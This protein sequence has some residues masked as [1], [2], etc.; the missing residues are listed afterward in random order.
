VSARLT[1]TE[2]SKR[3]VTRHGPVQALIPVNLDVPPGQF[4]SIVGPSGCGKSTLVRLISGLIPPTGGTVTLDG[5]VVDRPVT[6][7]GIVFQD[8]VLLDW[9]TTLGNV[10]L[11]GKV[12]GMPKELRERRGR[13]LLEMA[14]LS[15]FEDRRP[16]EL[17]GGMRQRVALCR[18][19]LHEPPLLLM[20]E[21]FGSL[22]ALTREQMASELQA[23][24]MR[25][26]PTMVFVTHSIPEAVT[27]SDRVI[28]MSSRPGR[29]LADIAV[30]LPRPRVMSEIAQAPS[31]Y[32]PVSEIRSLLDVDRSVPAG[33]AA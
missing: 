4:V 32:E 31:F 10:A 8:P 12:R 20:D 2:L 3:F 15:G 18:A 6:D 13:E 19:L 30:D 7:V 9:K 25:A 22:D 24:W 16:Y 11:Q 17:S 23:L 28:V 33:A 29:I 21:A 5:A 14:G 26:K 27:L 1:L